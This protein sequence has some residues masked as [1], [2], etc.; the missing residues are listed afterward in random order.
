MG[1]LYEFLRPSL[2]TL[3]HLKFQDCDPGIELDNPHFLDFRS[4]EPACISLRELEYTTFSRSTNAL[5][6]V[7]GMFSSLTHLQMVFDAYRRRDR[8]AWMLCQTVSGH[9]NRH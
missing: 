2:S 5:E 9:P 1:H 3:R 4:L 7:A 6:A 8:A